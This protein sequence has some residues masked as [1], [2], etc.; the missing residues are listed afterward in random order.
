MTFDP[1]AQGWKTFETVG[2]GE[3]AGPFW[4]RREGEG[5]AYGLLV[6]A[7]H[8]N[9]GGIVHGGLLA[10]FADIAMGRTAWERVRPNGC[11]TAQLNMHYVAPAKVGDFIEARAEIVEMTRSLVFVH[12]RCAAGKRVIVAADGI[13]K[14]LREGRNPPSQQANA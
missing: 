4:A 5:W 14:I 12:A 2:F 7:R 13:W 9:R 11:A 3:L 10:T 1:A 8:L 6:E